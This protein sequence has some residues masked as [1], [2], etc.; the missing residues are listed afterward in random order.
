MSY[1]TFTTI[2]GTVALGLLKN[3]FGSHSKK[4]I[5]CDEVEL[6]YTIRLYT[7]TTMGLGRVLPVDQFNQNWSTHKFINKNNVIRVSIKCVG[8]HVDDDFGEEYGEHIYA[9]FIV[10]VTL[11]GKYNELPTSE[12]DQYSMALTIFEA[13]KELW[14]ENVLP[15]SH[16]NA[17]TEIQ[18]RGDEYKNFYSIQEFLNK[19]TD[20]SDV[21]NS[22]FIKHNGIKQSFYVVD[23]QGNVIDHTSINPSKLR[24]R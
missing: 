22:F 10:T 9:Y 14:S 7:E 24:K 23:E 5:L 4:V 1:L 15:F 3:K 18:L 16:P 12:E 17:E 21:T 20:V 8:S 2:L 19:Y 6:D 11:K 13:I